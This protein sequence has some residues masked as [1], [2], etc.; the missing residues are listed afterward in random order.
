[1]NMKRLVLT[2]LVALFMVFTVSSI[3]EKTYAYWATNITQPAVGETQG[4]ITIG[5]WSLYEDWQ[6]GVTYYKGDIVYHNG[7]YY[8]ALRTTTYQPGSGWF[9][10]YFWKTVTI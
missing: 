7:Q 1:M 4:V 2:L 8:E 9:W 3:S 6:S 10:W 5:T